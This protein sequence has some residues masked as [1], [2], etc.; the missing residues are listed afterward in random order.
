MTNAMRRNQRLL[1]LATL[2]G[3]LALSASGRAVTSQN[4]ADTAALVASV[5]ERVE[6]YY[7]RLT[8]I[9]CTEV[10][11]Q[12]ELKS[13]L[14]PRGK[15]LEFVY[16]LIV[17]RGPSEDGESR[18]HVRAERQIR[19]RNGK[20]V[21][22]R[23][24]AACTDP[25]PAY[26]DPLTFLLPEKRTAYRFTSRIGPSLVV[27]FDEIAA[28]P[29]KVTGDTSCL[30]IEGGRSTGRLII[31]PMTHDVVELEVHLAEPFRAVR[32][33]LSRLPNGLWFH[34][35][36]RWDMAVHFR[37]VAFD[38]PAEDLLLPESIVTVSSLTD[39]DRPRVKTTQTFTAFKRFMTKAVIKG[40][41]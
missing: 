4:G 10:V 20:P 12:Q 6:S 24:V 29:T 7:D 18:P 41:P 26:E 22:K 35:V 38:D 5:A 9:A 23:D 30:R 21:K 8:T 36:E 3:T 19:T 40:T 1:R 39:T 28:P 16:D 31:D 17:T 32:P 13:D 14:T 15:P 11:T 37:R 34:T 25:Q 33:N 2:C 27:E